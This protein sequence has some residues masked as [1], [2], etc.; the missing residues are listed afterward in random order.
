MS[1]PRRIGRRRSALRLSRHRSRPTSPDAELELDDPIV[2][3]ARQLMSPAPSGADEFDSLVL[4]AQRMRSQ[5][6]G[7]IPVRGVGNRFVGMLSDRDI[8]E[9]CV[10]DAR[11]PGAVPACAVVGRMCPVVRADQLVD[12]SVR[13]AAKSA[14]KYPASQRH[15]IFATPGGSCA[16]ARSSRCAGTGRGSSSAFIRSA[17]RLTP[18][19][20]QNPMCGR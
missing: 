2:A 17:A 9:R 13:V 14:A 7:T 19:S 4:A 16:I 15:R 5:G 3:T 20:A 18:P 8:V 12:P 1:G 6:A 11:D 10:A